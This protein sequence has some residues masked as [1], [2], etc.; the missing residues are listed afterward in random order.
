MLKIIHTADIHAGKPLSL[1]LDKQKR[2]I[3]RREI[4]TGLWRIIDLVKQE[5][6]HIL[7]IAGDM[8]EHFYTR[9]SWVKDVALLFATIPCTQVFISPGNHDPLLPDSLYHSVKWPQNV[10]IFKSHGI[11][12]VSLEINEVKIDIYGFGWPSAL[13]RNALLENF[14]VK[15]LD[16][17]NIVL[18]HG[19][20]TESSAYLPIRTKHIAQSGADYFA[21]GHIHVPSI[22]KIANSTVIYP[23]CPEPLSFG[24]EGK[25]GVYLVT[26]DMEA[27][28]I[29]GVSGI[30]AEFV[31]IAT[32][33]VKTATVDLS[34]I[35]TGEQLRNAILSVAPDS[36][37][38][39]HLWKL[40]LKGR[41]SPEI[42]LDL[43]ALNHEFSDEFFCL[44]FVP[45]FVT[46]YD[47]EVL[48]RPENQSLEARFVQALVKHKQNAQVKGDFDEV[49]IATRALHYGLDALRQGEIISKRRLD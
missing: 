20:L 39:K 45:E 4:E 2:Y 15:H 3:R 22:T 5:N 40:I 36:I 23:G 33:A 17:F 1:G 42:G 25:R 46:D 43:V 27:K 49:D 14:K 31:P 41:L 18:L 48:M 21:L 26:H 28:R 13:H 24:D 47:L 19:D 9:S 44:R 12:K 11:T 10:T 8:F 29:K 30:S 35:D 6:A 16:H 7:L 38:R 37:R 32:R 34:L